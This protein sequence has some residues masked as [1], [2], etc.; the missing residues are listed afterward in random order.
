M[1]KGLF[2]KSTIKALEK[3]AEWTHVLEFNPEN[4]FKCKNS[5]N[6]ITL[7]KNA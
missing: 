3:G 6:L 7:A 1:K 2:H 4:R 5:R